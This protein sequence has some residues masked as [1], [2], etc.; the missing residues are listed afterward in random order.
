MTT[1]YQVEGA[2]YALLR[3]LAPPRR[4]HLVVNLQP[5]GMIYEVM[6]RR[7]QSPAPDLAQIKDSAAKINGFTRAAV[8]SC[9]DVMTWLSPEE[10]ATSTVAEGVGECLGLL[11]GNFNFRGFTIAN[12]VGALDAAVSRSAI[13][14]LLTAAMLAATDGRAHPADLVLRAEASAGRAVVSIML[15]PAEDREGFPNEDTYRPL[16]WGDVQ[17]LARAESVELSHT[18]KLVSLSFARITQAV[19]PTVD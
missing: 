8:R 9:L 4:H 6:E 7:L 1:D 16:T 5:I 11:N 19:P 10:G 14:C 17:A 2:R 3:R 13:R 15:K 12:E 18:D